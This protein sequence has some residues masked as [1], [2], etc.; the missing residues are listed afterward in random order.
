MD[1]CID[2]RIS[3][4]TTESAHTHST[5]RSGST[6]LYDLDDPA[7]LAKSLHEIRGGN[8]SNFVVDF[9]DESAFVQFNLGAKAFSDILAT[10]RVDKLSTRWINVWYPY[11]QRGTL[12]VLARRYDFSPRLLALMYSDPAQE[13]RADASASSIDQSSRW[14]WRSRHG[15]SVEDKLEAGLDELADQ[16]SIC[17]AGS[18]GESNIYWLLNDIWHYASVDFGRNY[19]CVGYNTLHGTKHAGAEEGPGLLP[20]CTRTWTWLLLCEDSTVITINEDPFPTVEGELSDVQQRILVETRRNVLNVFRSLSTIDERDLMA[21]NPMTVLP[22]RTRIGDTP[23]ET[24]HRDADAPGLLFYYLFENWQKSYSMVTRKDSRFDV[25]LQRI[26]KDMFQRPDLGQ[27]DRLDSI[28]K[29]LGVLRRHYESYNRI[30]LRLLEPVK[31]TGASLASSRVAGQLTSQASFETV[32]PTAAVAPGESSLG[33]A[34]SAAARVRFKRLKDMIDL[35]ALS[36][37]EEYIKQKDSLVAMVCSRHRAEEFYVH[38]LMV[39]LAEFQ[40]YSDQTID[41]RGTPYPSHP[42]SHESYLPISTYQLCD[43]LL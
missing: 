25:E 28:G 35:Y 32:R 26:R 22:I 5:N 38:I 17:S 4:S 11:H 21:K 34:L 41:R 27:V 13:R 14:K 24:A 15:R 31:I 12:E 1:G 42:S 39:A 37:V 23:E 10:D 18:L 33:V 9:S 36:D 2:D 40:P 16:A 20:H 19:V 8:I 30:I 6:V 29:E 3:S 7:I 43:R